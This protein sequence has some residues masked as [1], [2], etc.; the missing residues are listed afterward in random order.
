[1]TVKEALANGYRKGESAYQRKYISRKTDIDSQEVKVAGGSRKGQLYYNAPCW[2]STNY[3][4]RV[5][6][7]KP[8]YSVRQLPSGFWAVFRDDH[9]IDASSKTKEDALRLLDTIKAN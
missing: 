1:M 2:T 6:L 4:Y 8:K 7:E 9:W 5:Y 3:S